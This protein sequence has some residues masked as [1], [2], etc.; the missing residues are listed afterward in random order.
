M[1]LIF[2]LINMTHMPG[3]IEDLLALF[4]CDEGDEEESKTEPK[5]PSSSRL[6]ELPYLPKIQDVIFN[7]PATIIKW[8]DGTKTVVKCGKDDTYD[9]EKGFA[10]ALLKKLFGN[11]GSYNEIFKKWCW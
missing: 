9:K 7:Q 6:S 11:N 10:M 2:D 8:E 1:P 4:L 3:D 5:K